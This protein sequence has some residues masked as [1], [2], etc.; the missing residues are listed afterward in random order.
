MKMSV[1]LVKRG[2][3]CTYLPVIDRDLLSGRDGFSS[4]EIRHALAPPLVSSE[5]AHRCTS[6]SN[7]WDAGVAG[8]GPQLHNSSFLFY[9]VLRISP[10]G[11]F[12]PSAWPHQRG[13]ATLPGSNRGPK[14]VLDS[15]GN[16]MIYRTSLV[17]GPV[18]HHFAH[19]NRGPKVVLDS[20]GNVMIYR[21]SLV[22]GPVGSEWRT[23][24]H[25]QITTT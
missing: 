1:L 24:C 16:V 14:V 21:T 19:R 2:R 9:K 5:V 10:A 18:D 7:N 20:M 12:I 15:M 23:R 3:E 4:R 8:C 25:R 13:P 6:T 11:Q 17:A 22:A